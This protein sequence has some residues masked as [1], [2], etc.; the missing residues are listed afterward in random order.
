M[1]TLLRAV[2]IFIEVMLLTVVVY[3]VLNGVRL[4][5]FD[6]GIRPKYEKVVAMALIAVGCLVVVFII[7]HLTTFYPAIPLGK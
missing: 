5:I 6:L 1:E 7:A 2:T 3:V 4:T